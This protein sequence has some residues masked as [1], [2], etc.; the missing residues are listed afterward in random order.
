VAN[1]DKSKIWKID[2]IEK[3]AIGRGNVIGER[4]DCTR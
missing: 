3:K 4:M 1:K 2:G